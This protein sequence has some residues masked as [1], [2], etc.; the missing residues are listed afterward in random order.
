MPREGG[1]G[2]VRKTA[3][4][5]DTSMYQSAKSP[6]K[7]SCSRRP[8]SASSSRSW[9][10]VLRAATCPPPPPHWV[11]F[12]PARPYLLGSGAGAKQPLLLHRAFSTF[13]GNFDEA[14]QIAQDGNAGWP[15]GAEGKGK[16]GIGP[17]GAGGA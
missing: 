11:R 5:G 2:A 7:K 6:Q 15:P 12:Q 1:E 8:A 9:A 14:C 13:H 3:G 17:E 4:G 10:A 16:G